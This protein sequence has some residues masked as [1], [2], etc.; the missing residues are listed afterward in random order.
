MSLKKVDWVDMNIN[1]RQ[2]CRFV[3]RNATLHDDALVYFDDS[4]TGLHEIMFGE[5]SFFIDV[6]FLFLVKNKILKIRI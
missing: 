6:I 5:I 2:K 1:F 4:K 3:R